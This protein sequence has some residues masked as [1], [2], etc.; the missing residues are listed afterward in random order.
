M[1]VSFKT[2]GQHT[3]N[4]LFAQLKRL[5]FNLLYYFQGLNVFL[6]NSLLLGPDAFDCQSNT[7]S[8]PT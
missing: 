3:L 6:S 8:F 5:K 4:E 2:R 1:V 7:F